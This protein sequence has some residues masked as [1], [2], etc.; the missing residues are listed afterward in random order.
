MPLISKH[1]FTMTI[2]RMAESEYLQLQTKIFEQFPN[3][4]FEIDCITDIRQLDEAFT[5][6]A[7]IIIKDDRA[8]EHNYYYDNLSAR[9]NPRGCMFSEHDIPKDCI[10]YEN[11]RNEFINYLGISEIKEGT[12]IT[13]RQVL[14]AMIRSPHYNNDIVKHDPHSILEGFDT[15][16]NG[17]VFTPFFGS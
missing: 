17:V 3:K 14:T 9:G 8:N 5:R 4:P 12:P 13:L 15:S 1:F 16:S 6:Q 11:D 7:G 10:F 2:S